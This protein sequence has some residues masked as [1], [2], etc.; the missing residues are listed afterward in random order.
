MLVNEESEN[1]STAFSTG[2]KTEL[3]FQ[4]FKIFAVGGTMC[5]PD[6]DTTR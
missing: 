6:M 4:L 5:Q 3:I 1:A 2:D